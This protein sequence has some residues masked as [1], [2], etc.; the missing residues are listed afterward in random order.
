MR[1]DIENQKE[2]NSLNSFSANKDSRPLSSISPISNRNSNRNT[3][4]SNFRNIKSNQIHKRNKSVSSLNNH[5]YRNNII[6]ENF[7]ENQIKI[8]NINKDN[9]KDND[10][11][12]KM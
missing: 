12:N 3:F 8:F 7:K 1:K 4:S 5:N 9:E 11:K 10:N 6:T 2:I